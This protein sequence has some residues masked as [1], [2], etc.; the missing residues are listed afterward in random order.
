MKP[1]A[2]NYSC[3]ILRNKPSLHSNGLGWVNQALLDL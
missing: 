3:V 1:L 2:K